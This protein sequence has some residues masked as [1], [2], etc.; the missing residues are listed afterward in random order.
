[1]IY[2]VFLSHPGFNPRR[3]DGGSSDP[4]LAIYPIDLI[5]EILHLIPI[6]IMNK[7]GNMNRLRNFNLF[8]RFLFLGAMGGNKFYKTGFFN[9]G[10]ADLYD[11]VRYRLG[12]KPDPD[13]VLSMCCRDE[14]W[15][16]DQV[17]MACYNND[18]LTEPNVNVVSSNVGSIGVVTSNKRGILTNSSKA[19]H[20]NNKKGTTNDGVTDDHIDPA[21]VLGASSK[22]S[23]RPFK[24]GAHRILK[25]KNNA[26]QREKSNKKTREYKQ[27]NDTRVN[28]PNHESGKST[29][30]K[31]TMGS[32]GSETISPRSLRSLNLEGDAKYANHS[33]NES[34]ESD[35]T[36]SEKNTHS[37]T[38]ED[39]Y[40]N[41]SS[42]RDEGMLN[43]NN[44][45]TERSRR[46]GSL[47]TRGK[48]LA[49]AHEFVSVRGNVIK[50]RSL[51]RDDEV[52]S[53]QSARKL[54]LELAEQQLKACEVNQ[55][56]E[57]RQCKNS[58]NFL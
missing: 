28:L 24:G 6:Q 44:L 12:L 11:R 14:R 46:T 4:L 7:I 34:E 5:F 1:M 32:E 51:W 33:S 55:C 49:R 16:C 9:I 36:D 52:W 27:R 57:T 13:T 38:D 56:E 15:L 29:T 54:H 17:N 20:R 41:M 50:R 30:A 58:F 23:K 19:T 35:D 45:E 47:L 43:N 26:K 10:K 53:N 25:D 2:S 3:L 40:N 18:V 31:V 42:D 22:V 48:L 39:P 21:Q 37:G 8:R